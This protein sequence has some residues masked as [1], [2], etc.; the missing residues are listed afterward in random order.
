MGVNKV[1]RRN[2]EMIM[3]EGSLRSEGSETHRP[4]SLCRVQVFSV[5]THN[6][7]YNDY[8]PVVFHIAASCNKHGTCSLE[9]LVLF[10]P[11]WI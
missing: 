4:S 7:I 10:S 5:R 11:F 2:A 3:S 8:V 9:I 1:E 6:T